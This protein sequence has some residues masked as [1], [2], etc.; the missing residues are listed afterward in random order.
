MI[1]FF[2]SF[3]LGS[4]FCSSLICAATVNFPVDQAV[5]QTSEVL[6][7]R[8]T[9][10]RFT[11]IHQILQTALSVKESDSHFMDLEAFYQ[12]INYE[13]NHDNDNLGYSESVRF[14]SKNPGKKYPEYLKS[15]SQIGEQA[16]LITVTADLIT[17]SEKQNHFLTYQNNFLYQ[18]AVS[19][20]QYLYGR[21]LNV[22][23]TFQINA[24]NGLNWEY[25][26][27]GINSKDISYNVNVSGSFLSGQGQG[28]W[29]VTNGLIGQLKLSLRSDITSWN[30]Q[31]FSIPQ[32]VSGL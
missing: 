5:V 15:W 8:S 4:V 16:N 30:F 13:Y 12:S 19:S 20:L 17:S 27:T 10:D 29:N 24:K 25:K 21:D 6:Y 23:D 26:I 31:Y 32:K 11:R 1:K 3:L 7:I 14:N 18:G 22:G 2:Y 28:V 9:D